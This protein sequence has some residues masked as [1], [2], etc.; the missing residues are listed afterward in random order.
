MG[1]RA[2]SWL[3]SVKD[4]MVIESQRTTDPLPKLRVRMMKLVMLS[5]AALLLLCTQYAQAENQEA[6]EDCAS[7]VRTLKDR[8]LGKDATSESAFSE[9]VVGCKTDRELCRFTQ[10]WLDSFYELHGHGFSCE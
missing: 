1:L 4:R 10:E 6:A 8:A 7:V 2:P 9:S 3:L 5:A